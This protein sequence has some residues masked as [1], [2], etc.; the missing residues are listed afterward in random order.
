MKVILELFLA[1]RTFQAHAVSHRDGASKRK[2]QNTDAG[3][4]SQ[5]AFIEHY[6]SKLYA[7]I[8]SRNYLQRMTNRRNPVPKLRNII[9]MELFS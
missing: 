5:R 2:R 6:E 7:T 8:L 1:K 4:M 9:F 3:N